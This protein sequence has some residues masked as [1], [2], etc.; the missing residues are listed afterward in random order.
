M[1]I[2]L[3]A[4]N[5]PNLEE[6]FFDSYHNINLRGI[7][8]KLNT[9]YINCDYNQ[10]I[11]EFNLYS[12]MCPNL[13]ELTT[14]KWIEDALWLIGCFENLKIMYT[15]IN[16]EMLNMD[17]FPNLESMVKIEIENW[18]VKALWNSGSY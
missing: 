10:D 11:R 4:H 7:F 13:K 6:L 14:D 18:E 3:N 5:L 16:E 12:E 15:N 17:N 8:T 2:Y 9:I 1:N